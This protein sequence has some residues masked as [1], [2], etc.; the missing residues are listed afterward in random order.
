MQLYSF[1]DSCSY[2][3]CPC[4]IVYAKVDLAASRMAYARLTHAG[5]MG[6]G[7]RVLNLLDIRLHWP[8]LNLG[9]FAIELGFEKYHTHAH[10]F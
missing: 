8:I 5:R 7:W 6:R 4:P 1:L 9:R 3:L 10:A 2:L